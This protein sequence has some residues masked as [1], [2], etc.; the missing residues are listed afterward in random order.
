MNGNDAK[1]NDLLAQ[2]KEVVS[3][4]TRE[5]RV[6]ARILPKYQLDPRARQ[7]QADRLNVASGTIDDVTT[8]PLF[9]ISTQV[10]LDWQQLSEPGLFRAVGQVEVA[11]R[12]YARIEDRLLFL[13]F[14]PPAAGAGP[15]V[16]GQ[17]LPPRTT[18]VRGYANLG[19]VYEGGFVRPGPLS[20]MFD[21]ISRALGILESN[22]H[23]GPFG[24]AMSTDLVDLA[25]QRPA[26]FSE[27]NRERIESLLRTVI[28]RTPVLPRGTAVLMSGAKQLGDVEEQSSNGS[29]LVPAPPP[30]G[31]VDRAVAVDPSLRFVQSNNLGQY[32]FAVYGVLTLRIKDP[33]GVYTI[34]LR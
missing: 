23:Y 13:G 3:R 10:T 14:A 12:G 26:G 16:G 24:L 6:A 21:E 28:H 27:T 11:A 7:V 8:L 1:V 15:M 17:A 33:T 18:V 29:S 34:R 20:S 31:P 19:L 2:A 25:N 32:V 5:T 4:I 22:N 30:T 9:E